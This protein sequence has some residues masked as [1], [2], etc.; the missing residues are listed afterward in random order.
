MTRQLHGEVSFSIYGERYTLR[1]SLGALAA[2]EEQLGATIPALVDALYEQRA[3]PAAIRLILREGFI[4][5]CGGAQKPP[6]LFD[7]QL[8][9]LWPVVLIFLIHG[10][11]FLLIGPD[12]QEQEN[13]FE[14]A[15]D[16]GKSVA[17]SVTVPDVAVSVP[18]GRPK[19]NFKPLE[20]GSIY[21]SA[22]M[23]LNVRQSEYW[24]MTMPE[25]S[26]RAGML[27]RMHGINFGLPATRG[28]LDR[29]IAQFPDN[30]AA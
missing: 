26:R 5:Y 4:A 7:W 12:K 13:G 28:D 6:L 3:S 27:A 21:E 1:P 29:M 2:I 24:R 22:T 18:A 14:A 15:N 30:A 25:L 23:L 16:D 9:R 11:G 17:Q 10:M 19:F 20:W 8:R